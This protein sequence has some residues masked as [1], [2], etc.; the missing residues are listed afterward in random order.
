MKNTSDTM[1]IILTL[2]TSM[3][4]TSV[5]ELDLVLPQDKDEETGRS[6]QCQTSTYHTRMQYY[7]PV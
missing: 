5:V 6:Q 4:L 2:Y 1:A 7:R 3:L